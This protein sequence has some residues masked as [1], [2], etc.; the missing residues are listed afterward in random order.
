MP[1]IAWNAVFRSLSSTSSVEIEQ[2]S[3]VKHQQIEYN[4]SSLTPYIVHLI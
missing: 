1:L 2:L 3:Y 4:S